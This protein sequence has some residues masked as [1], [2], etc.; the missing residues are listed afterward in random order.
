[1]LLARSFTH[2]VSYIFLVC[3]YHSLSLSYYLYWIILMISFLLRLAISIICLVGRGHIMM[4]SFHFVQTYNS[5]VSALLVV[6]VSY[7]TFYNSVTYPCRHLPSTCL[8]WLYYVY[9]YVLSSRF[10]ER[11]SFSLLFIFGRHR[12]KCFAMFFSTSSSLILYITIHI[13]LI[14]F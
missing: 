11:C 4:R 7:L 3:L 6:V 2:S 1:M 12:S 13:Y 10:V 8:I 9:V 14:L 5:M